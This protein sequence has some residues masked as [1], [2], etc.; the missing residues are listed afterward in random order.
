MLPIK[1]RSIEMYIDPMNNGWESRYYTSLFNIKINDERRRE[2]CT[3]YLEGLE[4]TMKYYSTGCANWRWVY[5]YYYPPL[6]IDLI[7]YV[8]MFDHEFIPQ[9][10]KNPVSQLTQLSY[11]LPPSS[12]HLLPIE[13]K[14][15]LTS[16]HPEW[17]V[18]NYNF[19]W[20]FCKFFW[21]AHVDLPNIDIDVLEKTVKNVSKS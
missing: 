11:V 6:L 7:K 5:N 8:P 10:Q 19:L 14:K 9:Q 12:M 17:Y 18:G 4:W 21:E 13:L 16:D 15:K 2:I 1:E 3:N 20:S